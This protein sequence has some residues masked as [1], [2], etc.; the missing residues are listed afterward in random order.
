VRLGWCACVCV[1]V[2]ACVR[3]RVCARVRVRVCVC[4]CACACACARVCVCAC[5]R[6]CVCVCMYMYAYR[7]ENAGVFPGKMC[8][9][10][11][12]NHGCGQKKQK[13]LALLHLGA[14]NAAK[15]CEL[16]RC[17]DRVRSRTDNKDEVLGPVSRNFR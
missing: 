5:V 17:A 15:C 9:D 14:R 6:V 10:R 7:H 1:R 2:C 4:V 12:K 11:R 16:R 13:A 8:S 3:V